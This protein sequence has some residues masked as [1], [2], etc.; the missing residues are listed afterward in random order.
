VLVLTIDYADPNGRN[1]IKEI[2]EFA[3]DWI[4]F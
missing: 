4:R 3:L 2:F 1:S